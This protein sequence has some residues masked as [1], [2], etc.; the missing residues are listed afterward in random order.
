MR[1]VT[2]NP[3]AVEPITFDDLVKINCRVDTDDESTLFT[4]WIQS[5]REYCE[6]RISQFF[7]TRSVD[8]YLD[9]W[10]TVRSCW[11]YVY[12]LTGTTHYTHFSEDDRHNVI[13]IP[14]GPLQSVEG[15]TYV[16]STGAEQTWDTS[17][18]YVST[19]KR[20]RI[21]AINGFPDHLR[22]IDSIKISATFGYGDAASD[23]PANVIH[24]MLLYVGEANRQRAESTDLKLMVVPIAIDNLL[25][26]VSAG[27]EYVF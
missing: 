14:Y 15:I 18:Y 22:R 26:K 9:R 12:Y 5:A 11:P 1:L 4:T 13:H 17:E 6:A 20:P 16:D 27:G 7:I 2:T 21:Q 23:I 24:A 8:I 3:P 10:P 25:A 19:G